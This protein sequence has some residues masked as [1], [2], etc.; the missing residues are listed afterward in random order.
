MPVD[1]IELCTEFEMEEAR[2]LIELNEV[3]SALPAIRA[4]KKRQEDEYEV[5]L[6]IN[7]RKIVGRFSGMGATKAIPQLLDGKTIALTSREIMDGLKAEGW[8]TNATD[9]LAT[10]SATLSQLRG[11]VVDKVGDG[12]K[13]RPLNVI[14]DEPVIVSAPALDSFA[15]TLAHRPATS[16]WR[17]PD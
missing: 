6:A 12:W 17:Q 1:Y 11:S 4:R 9:P 14:P 8:T 7:E 15:V 16:D 3:R 10:V 13:L 2:L 5:D